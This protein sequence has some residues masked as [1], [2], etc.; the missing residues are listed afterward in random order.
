MEVLN[1]IKS[2]Y[3]AIIEDI[4]NHPDHVIMY[5]LVGLYEELCRQERENYILNISNLEDIERKAIL[6][7]HKMDKGELLTLKT[8]LETIFNIAISKQ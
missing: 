3:K 7:L 2:E 6:Y 8:L 5:D 4:Q 1:A